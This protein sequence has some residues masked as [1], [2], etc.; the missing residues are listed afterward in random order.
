MNVPDLIGLPDGRL[1]PTPALMSVEDAIQRAVTA[2]DVLILH[3]PPGTG[4][5]TAIGYWADKRDIAVARVAFANAPDMWAL[6]ER[7]AS[8]VLTDHSRR[9]IP[10][11]QQ[12]IIAGLK[13][14]PIPFWIDPDRLTAAGVRLV[15]Y[16]WEESDRMWPLFMS[17]SD[18]GFARI[19]NDRVLLDNAHVVRFREL[20]KDEITTWI[21]GYHPLFEDMPDQWIVHIDDR[22]AHGLLS[23]WRNFTR[24]AV[25]LAAEQGRAGAL[26]HGLLKAVLDQLDQ[27]P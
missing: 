13:V 24:S 9:S 2:S 7:I 20:T 6:T 21:P 12:R 14:K 8:A 10:E 23:R 19:A 27:R 11:L 16:I 15:R 25:A 1:V 22:Y 17:C 18:I 26:S 5:R 3:G 4:K